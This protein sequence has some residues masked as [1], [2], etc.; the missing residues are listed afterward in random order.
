MYSLIY[1]F[2]LSNSP[3]HLSKDPSP[4][5]LTSLLPPPDSPTDTV[6]LSL[7][8]P[9]TLIHNVLCHPIFSFLRIGL[10]CILSS[11]PYHLHRL[12]CP[13]IPTYHIHLSYVVPVSSFCLFIAF[14]SLSPFICHSFLFVSS[15]YLSLFSIISLTIHSI[16]ICYCPSPVQRFYL[17]FLA[18]LV[19]VLLALT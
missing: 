12:S 7:I 16:S 10:F 9:S 11:V 15:T 8:S 17:P 3:I 4:F 18:L 5:C 13:Y 1:L 19:F 6:P 14:N 2:R